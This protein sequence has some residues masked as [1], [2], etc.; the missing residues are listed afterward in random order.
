MKELHLSF[1]LIRVSFKK[2]SEAFM[3]MILMPVDT[4]TVF[5]VFALHFL[6][7]ICAGTTE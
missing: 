3:E 1:L 7:Q 4:W 6:R 5:L 2:R